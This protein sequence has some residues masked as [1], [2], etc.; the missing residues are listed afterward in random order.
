MPRRISPAVLLLPL[1]L[2][3]AGPSKLAERSH[4]KLVVGG[5]P[6]REDQ[7]RLDVTDDVDLD[8]AMVSPGR[9]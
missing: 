5:R 6:L 9:R 4:E 1:V 3:C 7:L 8:V 2:G